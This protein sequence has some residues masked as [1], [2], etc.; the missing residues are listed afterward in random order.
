MPETALIDVPVT[1]TGLWALESGF[2]NPN[3]P[4]IVIEATEI[5]VDCKQKSGIRKGGSAYEYQHQ[6]IIDTADQG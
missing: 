6:H 1:G 3:R 4:E 5:E 2:T